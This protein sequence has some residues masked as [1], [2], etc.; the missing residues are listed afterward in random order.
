MGSWRRRLAKERVARGSQA[1]G[2]ADASSRSSRRM[3]RR[4]GG[5]ASA[6][7]TRRRGPSRS[8]SPS[9]EFRQPVA[10]R[11]DEIVDERPYLIERKL[12]RRVRVE[13]GRVIDMLALA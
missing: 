2:S 7:V 5:G 12:R 6:R 10:M 13:H 8:E 4:A 1:P 11:L 3:R 9:V